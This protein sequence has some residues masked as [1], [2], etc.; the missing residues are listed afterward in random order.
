MTGNHMEGR[1]ELAV[2]HRN[3]GIGGHAVRRGDSRND[4]K[5]N[6]MSRQLKCLLATASKD[7]RI[8]TFQTND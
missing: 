5:R 3:S 6:S 2:R 7:I 1:S 4:L 8:S